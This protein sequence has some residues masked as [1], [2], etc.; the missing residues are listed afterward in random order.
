MFGYSQT[1]EVLVNQAIQAAESRNITTPA[2]VIQT[3]E[4]SGL[5]EAQARQ[6]AAQRGLSYEQLLNDFFLIKILK[7]LIL[8][9]VQILRIMMKL[10]TVKTKMIF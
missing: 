1:N 7:I 3:L 4:A 5:T 8:R 10:K 2:Q 6:L 9:K